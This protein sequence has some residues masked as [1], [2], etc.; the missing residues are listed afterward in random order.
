[1][2]RTT[3][4]MVSIVAVLALMGLALAVAASAATGPGT[5]T[6]ITTPS[7]NVIY[8]VVT[9]AAN[10]LTV[11]GQTSP[12]VTQVNID[13]I[14]RSQ[15]GAVQAA[16][17]ATSVPVVNHA[18]SATA[19]ATSL[20][21]NCRLRAVPS[22]VDPTNYA[23]LGSFSGPLF[24]SNSMTVLTPD[25]VTPAGYDASTGQGTGHLVGLDAAQCGAAGF[26][27]IATP[28][29]ET[30]GPLRSG[31][32]CLLFLGS[33]N[34]THGG[35]PTG[36]A[37]SVDG[38]IAYLPLHVWQF[39]T[40]NGATFA[41]T[42]LTTTLARHANG[43][44][45]ITESAPLVRCNTDTYPP[46]STCTS[47]IKTGVTF[48]RTADLFRGA[49]QIRFRDS[50]RSTDG[51][52][53]SV[54]ATYESMIGPP[55]TGTQGYRFPGHGSSYFKTTPDEVVTGLGAKAATLLVRSDIHAASDD[56]QAETLG[57]TW[58][59]APS[60]LQYSTSD[61]NTF[62]MPFSVSVPAGGKGYL[63]FAVSQALS[64][65]G[66]SS[67]AA[68]ATREMVA[69]PTITAPKPGAVIHGHATTVRGRVFLGA[70][71]MPTSVKV[72]GHAATLTRVSS[73]VESY[74]VTFSETY[75]RHK[76]TVVARDNAG[77][78]R[79]RSIHVTNKP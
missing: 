77:N 13:C 73:T 44:M 69:T 9:G 59:R 5:W 42:K 54:R 7:N 8:K 18:F 10:N 19:S 49:H 71:G 37:L 76:L 3:V 40:F 20:L 75:A 12:D 74:A 6:K 67:L 27:T 14:N 17:F 28:T 63:G 33:S 30:L 55:V 47:S 23:Y 31:S 39:R 51:K 64:T 45:T 32:F 41:Q 66:A 16:A 79:S 11:S 22:D 58:S 21:S 34:I 53:H 25:G 38:H 65:S 29:M 2:S 61:A 43:D 15:G 1:M 56:Q 50:F 57:L 26:L 46:D 35:T 52:K 48:M 70:N 4:R 36:T 62:V 24:Y 60:R 68:V 72:N 78:T